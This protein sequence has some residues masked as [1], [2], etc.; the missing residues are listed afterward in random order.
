MGAFP[1]GGGLPGRLPLL[2]GLAGFL[3]TGFLF[4]PD[5]PL[6]TLNQY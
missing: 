1:R 2:P 4:E 6:T 5:N 3:G